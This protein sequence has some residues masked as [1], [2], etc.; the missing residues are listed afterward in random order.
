MD[1]D[2]PENFR[3]SCKLNKGYSGISLPGAFQEYAIVEHQF[4]VRIPDQL[5]SVRAAQLTC[6]GCTSWR[7]VKRA[8]FR[9]ADSC[10]LWG[11]MADRDT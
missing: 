9:L 1:Y 6:A 5:S 2:G 3:L 7:A 10:V 8:G 4:G 11:V